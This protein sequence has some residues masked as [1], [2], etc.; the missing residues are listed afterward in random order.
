MQSPAP[1][2]EQPGQ[3]LRIGDVARL[4]GTTPRTIRYYEEIGLLPEAPTRPSGRHRLY[5]HEEVER[6]REVMRL[7]EL[8]GVSLEELKTLLT[9]EEARAEVRAQLRQED[10][11]PERRRELL[12]E[13][14]GHIDRQ[15]ELVRHR[16]LELAKLEHELGETHKRVK[17][18]IRELDAQQAGE[19]APE[20]PLETSGGPTT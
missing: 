12:L 5:S 9:A 16:A 8:L 3:S 6:L 17:R 1:S 14:Q 11:D 4:V 13:A 10:V 18:R 7:K 2:P 19:Y 20:P 15:L